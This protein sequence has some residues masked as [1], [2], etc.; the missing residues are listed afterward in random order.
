MTGGVTIDSCIFSE[1]F[2]VLVPM[3]A[4]FR[5]SSYRLVTSDRERNE[6]VT[7][8]G[9]ASRSL[10]GELRPVPDSIR[11]PRRQSV[12]E[13]P[14]DHAELA[15]VVPLMG[16]EIAQEVPEIGGEVLPGRRWDTAAMRMAQFN[17]SD[18]SVAAAGQRPG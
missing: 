2:T 9:S 14:H 7:P 6:C 18:D 3:A 15:P 4:S 12:P 10:S 16:D 5:K 8:R 17:E 1:G 11:D 13:L